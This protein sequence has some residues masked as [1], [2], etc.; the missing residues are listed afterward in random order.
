MPMT[1]H[2]EASE[3]PDTPDEVVGV[4]AQFEGPD[5]LLEAAR[6]VRASGYK[7]WDTHSPY[8]IHGMERA[9]G[10]RP[11]VLPWL[12]FGAG[13]T[14]LAIAIFMQWWTNATSF[15]TFLPNSLRGYPFLI[16]G[17]P[18]FSLPANI[19]VAFELVVLLSA[20][21]AFLGSLALNQLP[22]FTHGVF[23]SSAFRR[24]T[25]D[26]FFV[27]VEARDGQF[28][29]SAT[30]DLLQSLG[31]TSVEVCRLPT[32]GRQWPGMLNW[33]GVILVLL[34]C[35]PPLLIA[36]ARGARSE[37]PR[38]HIVQDMDFQP[39]YLSQSASPLFADGRAIRPPVPGTV[40]LGQLQREAL[41]P[42]PDRSGEEATWPRGFP[43]QWEITDRTMRRG[44][45][46]YEIFCATCH[47]LVGEGGNS[48]MTSR[49]AM[50]RDDSQWIPPT[51]LQDPRILQMPEGQI[52]HVITHG[53]QRAGTQ[54][55]P[56]YDAQI[57]PEDRWA[58]VLYVRALQRSQNASADDVPADVLPTLK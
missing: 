26:G 42:V 6:E 43:D 15:D 9:M 27:S 40:A 24:A 14:G 39:K 48:G 10:I 47:G 19:A 32:A 3:V 58:I 4:V 16:S 57:D 23:A 37:N 55:M 30:A 50:E 1:E 49:R 5:A 53:V 56:A 25:S 29:E 2:D 8:P 11:T 36:Q 18:Y 41:L 52:F 38:I 28:D 22:Q 13:L 21:A 51:A 45:E 17:K 54:S 33:A 44:R 12:V 46:R 7:R 31:A 34:A 20:F 35:V